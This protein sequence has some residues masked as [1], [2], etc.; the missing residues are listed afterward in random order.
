MVRW[1]EIIDNNGTI[2]R[3]GRTETSDY[4]GMEGITGLIVKACLNLVNIKERTATLVKLN[5]IDKIS[6]TLQHIKQNKNVSMIEFL[7]KKVSSIINLS[8]NYHL[9]VEYEDNSGLL[10]NSEYNEL[11][12]KRNFIYPKLAEE[13]YTKIEDPVIMTNKIDTLLNFLE[14]KEIPTYGHISI[15]ILH[16]CFNS[17]Q[18]QYIPEMMKLVKKLSGKISGEHGIGIL[19]KKFVDPND[20]K[21]LQNIK[22]RTD[23]QNKFN[24]G[25]VI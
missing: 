7:D 25:K 13:G 19:Q 20:K 17:Q 1:I 18:E 4:C 14:K 5:N 9:I 3:K 6:E 22:K 2:D 11:M 10:K 16:P 21:I 24:M 23:P 15:G 8:N 12:K